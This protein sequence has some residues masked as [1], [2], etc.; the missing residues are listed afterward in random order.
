MTWPDI[1]IYT[2]AP[3]TMGRIRTNPRLDDR[4]FLG[5]R[6][7]GGAVVGERFGRI[8]WRGDKAGRDDELGAILDGHVEQGH[9]LRR[10]EEDE[11]RGRIGR[12]RHEYGHQ[13]L[14]VANLVLHLGRRIAGD[15]HDGVETAPG[16]LDEADALE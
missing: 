1:S 4:L 3:P 12:V 11:A 13:L 7:R 2:D 8:L 6:L 16:K 10:H 15:E 9:V 5:D 14:A